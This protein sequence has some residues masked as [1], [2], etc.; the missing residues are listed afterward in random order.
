MA[1]P[2]AALAAVLVL[3]GSL[4]AS[5]ALR[6]WRLRRRTAWEVERAAWR[7]WLTRP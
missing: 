1:S 5:R 4:A 7:A 2:W 3:G 6:G